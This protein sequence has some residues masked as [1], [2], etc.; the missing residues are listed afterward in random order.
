MI[1][2]NTVYNVNKIFT[3]NIILSKN[4]LDKFVYKNKFKI[5][6]FTIKINF[7]IIVYKTTFCL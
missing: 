2:T 6:I 4:K 1:K 5:V 7:A 3:W